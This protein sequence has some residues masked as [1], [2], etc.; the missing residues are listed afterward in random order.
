MIPVM[1]GGMY[2][3]TF[4]FF[5]DVA[6]QRREGDVRIDGLRDQPSEQSTIN[7]HILLLLLL[8]LLTLCLTKKPATISDLVAN[9]NI[10][11]KIGILGICHNCR[12][13]V[14]SC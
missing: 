1:F 6:I 2:T 12:A 9:Q 5:L 4:L 14:Q 3:F 10:R 8:L 11:L 7:L 13:F